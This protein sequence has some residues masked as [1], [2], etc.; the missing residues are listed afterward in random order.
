MH[1]LFLNAKWNICL[2]E[3]ISEK[4]KEN[5]RDWE[6]I[7]QSKVFL[8]VGWASSPMKHS[9]KIISNMHQI[10]IMYSYSHSCSLANLMPQIVPYSHMNQRQQLLPH[11]F[12]VVSLSFLLFFSSAILYWVTLGLGFGFANAMQCNA[13]M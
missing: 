8:V 4:E 12:P 6:Q 7:K 2:S 5:E 11:F 10:S 13:Q 1:F 9:W 3:N